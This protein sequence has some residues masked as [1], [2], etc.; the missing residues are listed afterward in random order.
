LSADATLKLNATRSPDLLEMVSRM[1][2]SS[3]NDGQRRI[4]VSL[5]FGEARIEWH[6]SFSDKYSAMSSVDY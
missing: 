1:E 4:A 5:L 6:R 3:I 2:S